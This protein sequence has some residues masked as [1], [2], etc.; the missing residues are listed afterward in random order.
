MSAI[1]EQLLICLI[2]AHALG[3]FLLQSD[4]AVGE[5][6]KILVLSRHAFALAAL[7]YLLCGLWGDWRIPTFIFITHGAI[8]SVKS[9]RE[10]DDLAG[11]LLDQA[12]HL[13]VIAALAFWT[14]GGLAATSLFWVQHL[15]NHYLMG[16]T[17]VTGSVLTIRAC[18][19]AIVIAVK[20]LLEQIQALNRECRRQ[21]V[22]GRRGLENGGRII[23]QWERALIFVLVLAGYPGGIGWLI[24]A[25]SIFRFGELKDPEQR[26]EAEYIIIGTLMSFVLGAILAFGTRAVLLHL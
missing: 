11:F 10:T 21:N 5:K 15:G 6:K 7:S 3:D 24:A 20:P 9:R 26:M 23:G 1:T 17:V 14:A 22:P 2:T 18:G 13:A 25:K 8:D 16:L 4:S 12:A 19:F